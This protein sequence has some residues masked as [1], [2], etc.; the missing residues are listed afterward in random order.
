MVEDHGRTMVGRFLKD[1]IPIS[2]NSKTIDRDITILAT[3]N[4]MTVGPITV[5]DGYTVTVTD[6]GTWVVI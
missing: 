4:A 2:F 1:E 5:S 6:G 3:D